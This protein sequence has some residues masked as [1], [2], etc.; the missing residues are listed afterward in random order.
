MMRV[1]ISRGVVVM[2]QTSKKASEL[3]NVY[4][5]KKNID[6]VPRHNR[7]PIHLF[8]HQ[9]TFILLTHCYSTREEIVAKGVYPI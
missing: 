2:M 7:R 3:R 1:P 8:F 4:K 5:G 9:F 6:V